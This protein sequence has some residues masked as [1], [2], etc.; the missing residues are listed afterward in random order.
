MNLVFWL[1]AVLL[2]GLA[3]T[4]LGTSSGSG[5]QPSNFIVKVA[6]ALS[7][8]AQSYNDQYDI[9]DEYTKEGSAAATT[10]TA[11]STANDKKQE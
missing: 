6:T 10:T 9:N 11:E 7:D 1:V 8:F 3:A 5:N 4:I 2:F